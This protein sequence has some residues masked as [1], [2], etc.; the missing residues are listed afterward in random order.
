MA[1]LSIRVACGQINSL[2][3]DLQANKDKIL[4]AIEIARA[5]S[6]DIICFPE[7]ALVGYPPEDLL[8]KPKLIS[9]E[10]GEC[11]SPTNTEV[12]PWNSKN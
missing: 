2:V 12:K 4:G 10:T 11:R 3:G 7:L 9:E 8:F 5:Q 1:K 6:V